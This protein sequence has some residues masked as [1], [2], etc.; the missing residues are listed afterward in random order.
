MIYSFLWD[1]QT[2]F[3]G[4]CS[5]NIAS[6]NYHL[7]QGER[8]HLIDYH[9]TPHILSP[10]YVGSAT[11]LEAVQSLYATFNADGLTLWSPAKINRALTAD[12]FLVGLKARTVIRTHNVSCKLDGYRLPPRCR[13]F[14]SACKHTSTELA[15][16]DGQ[17]LKEEFGNLLAIED[18]QGF[19]LHIYLRQRHI[20]LEV[21][22]EVMEAIR[23]V[24]QA[25][26]AGGGK[27]DVIWTYRG[28]SVGGKAPVEDGKLIALPINDFLDMS[29]ED[30]RH[31]MK[32][33][34]D[35]VSI[36]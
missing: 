18:K 26:I 2:C 28:N 16:I 36:S 20:S 30:W 19:S 27:V 34:L 14:T 33:Y 23:G 10:D 6:G 1:S 15:H 31:K 13:K 8:L 29:R 11:A 3:V 32:V 9:V 22:A 5:R 24:R 7:D 21:V 25:F 17:L 35:S 4:H 12:S